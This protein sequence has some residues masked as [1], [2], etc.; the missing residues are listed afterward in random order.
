MIMRSLR[1]CTALRYCVFWKKPFSL[2]GFVVSKY[3][4]LYKCWDS[5]SW[6]K[7]IDIRIYKST[8]DHAV[9]VIQTKND[10]IRL[11][12]V[13]MKIKNNFFVWNGKLETDQQR[14]GWCLCELFEVCSF[15]SIWVFF[16]VHSRLTGQQGK[17]KL[18]M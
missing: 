9:A 12:L 18:S 4:I 11:H 13:I 5:N 2:A 16:Q 8:E 7:F 10:H 6:Y 15:F 17:G 14:S 3:A 1:T